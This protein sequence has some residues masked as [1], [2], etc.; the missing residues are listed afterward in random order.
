MMPIDFIKE[1][2]L[3]S[4]CQDWAVSEKSGSVS[5]SSE[6]TRVTYE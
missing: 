2:R 4:T 1:L 5:V 6:V 3:V